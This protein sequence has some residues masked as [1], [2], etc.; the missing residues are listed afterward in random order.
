M[1]AIDREWRRHL[2]LCAELREGAHLARLGGRVPLV[3]YT[4]AVLAAFAELPGRVDDATREALDAVMVRAGRL[5]VSAA[6]P[7]APTSTWTYLVN[8]DPFR[9]TI[10]TLLTAPGG[11]TMAIYAAA[12]VGPLLALWGTVSR[13]WCRRGVRASRR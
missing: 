2:A 12:L 3:V 7:P 13:W 9:H 8:D 4:T 11:Q 10:G 5:E 6:L 1:G